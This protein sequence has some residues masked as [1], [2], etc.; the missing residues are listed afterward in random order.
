MRRDH[1][2]GRPSLTMTQAPQAKQPEQPQPPPLAA[3]DFDLDGCPPD[4]LEHCCFYEYALEIPSVVNA[5]LRHRENRQR[6]VQADDEI[7]D[8]IAD[9]WFGSPFRVLAE[10]PEFP[11]KHWL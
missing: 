1:K 3:W 11:H 2:T 9:R 5:V 10:H 8:L 4:E 7:G 6:P